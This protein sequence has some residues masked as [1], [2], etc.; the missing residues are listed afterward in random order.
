MCGFYGCI[1]K[2]KKPAHSL[3][4]RGPNQYGN[5]VDEK[6]SLHQWRLSILDLHRQELPWNDE[7]YWLLYNGEI[8][9]YVELKEELIK[10]GHNFKTTCD[11]EVVLKAFKQWYTECLNKFI[12][13]WAIVLINKFTGE[14]IA[15]RDIAGKKPLFYREHKDYLEFASEIKAFDNLEYEETD[16]VKYWE[17]CVNDETCFKNVKQVE[18]ATYMYFVYSNVIQSFKYF[19]IDDININDKITFNEAVEQLDY[20]LCDSIKLRLRSDV[21]TGQFLS[22]GWDSSLL[23]FYLK[24]NDVAY[25]DL[26]DSSYEIVKDMTDKKSLLMS[27]RYF[28]KQELQDDLAKICYHLE[29][30]VGHLSVPV[31]WKLANAMKIHKTPVVYSGEGADELFN[32][33]TRNEI[34]LF[35]NDMWYKDFKFKGYEPVRDK[36]LGHIIERLARLYTR[37]SNYDDLDWMKSAIND[38]WNYDRPLYWNLKKLEFSIGLQPLLQ[39]SDR[40][41][42]A[43]SIELRCPY[44]DKNIIKFA[45]SL[46]SECTWDGKKGKTI[47]KQLFTN[48]ANRIKF[49]MEQFLEYNK[50]KTGMAI[51]YEWYSKN[52]V[53]RQNWNNFLIQNIK[54]QLT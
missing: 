35:E 51:P 27:T 12:G 18:P 10:L 1:G 42:M 53:D 24:P 43:H 6:L 19:D 46:P 39:I 13:I 44:L 45:F 4:H 11:A 30:P 52:I 14:V 17:F 5:H 50:K 26:D 8:Y 28:T 47:L 54:E 31:W 23:Y 41:T 36:Y 9:N 3:E 16:F 22:G 49:N 2:N 48:T 33:Y 15:S 21:P 34:V 38:V 40:M 20:L 37:H 32:G 29:M 25:Y 7:A